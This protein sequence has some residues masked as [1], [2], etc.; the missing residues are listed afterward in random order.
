MYFSLRSPLLLV[1]FRNGISLTSAL[2]ASWLWRCWIKVAAGGSLKAIAVCVCICP[3]L[4]YRTYSSGLTVCDAVVKLIGVWR[5]SNEW[6]GANRFKVVSSTW[7][8]GLH[9]YFEV[10]ECHY[11]TE[12]ALDKKKAG[13]A[14]SSCFASLSVIWR[15]HTVNQGSGSWYCK[16]SVLRIRIFKLLSKFA[17]FSTCGSLCL[18][19]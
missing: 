6:Q 2:V 7:R 5:G 14:S 11:E 1:F 17:E 3:A 10:C 13:T 16:L 4:R 15:E 9:T 12:L 8:W 19:I 18:K